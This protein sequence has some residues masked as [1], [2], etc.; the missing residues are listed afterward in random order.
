[1]LEGD[2]KGYFDNIDHQLLAN[3]L[4]TV[5]KDKNLIAIYWKL[6]KAGYVNDGH[7]VRSELGVLQ[8]GVL[9]PL[10]SNLYMHDFDMF[11]EKLCD[12][13]TTDTKVSKV[14]PEYSR[15]KRLIGRSTEETKALKALLIKIPVNIRDDTT[16]TRV[17]YNRYA[18]D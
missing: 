6:V 3:K 8:G 1:M 18:D 12:I 14:N 5:I 2:I 7:S 15:I 13:Y 11:M 9:S 17:Y 16:G 10:L 4:E